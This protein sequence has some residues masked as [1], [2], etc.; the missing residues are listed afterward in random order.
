[1]RLRVFLCNKIKLLSI[2]VFLCL[3]NK[4]LRHSQTVYIKPQTLW[5]TSL[6]AVWHEKFCHDPEVMGSNPS[7]VKLGVRVLLSNSDFNQKSN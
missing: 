6:T 4:S 5:H 1:M 7:Q 2:V 3:H